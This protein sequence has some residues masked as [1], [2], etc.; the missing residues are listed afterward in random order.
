MKRSPF[1]EE[2]ADA[3][4]VRFVDHRSA[5]SDLSLFR[6]PDHLNKKGAIEYAPKLHAACF[7][8]AGS[9]RFAANE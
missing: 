4:G 6:D 5:F 9:D 7:D 8:N 3:P 1:F 2:L